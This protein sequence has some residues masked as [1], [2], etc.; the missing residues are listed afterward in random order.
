MVWHSGA[1]W[2]S[3]KGSIRFVFKDGQEVE[4]KQTRTYPNGKYG[5]NG[6][7][8]AKR[9]LGIFIQMRLAWAAGSM[10]LC[11]PSRAF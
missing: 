11:R 3:A 1:G 8:Q 7:A 4:I 2:V 10:Q 6:T 9:N 5:Q